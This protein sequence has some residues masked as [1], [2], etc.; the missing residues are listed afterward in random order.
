[1]SVSDLTKTN[2][3]ECVYLSIACWSRTVWQ[4]RVACH[5]AVWV[6][7]SPVWVVTGIITI[8]III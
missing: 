3:C 6:V 5:Q 4:W 2:T 8:I 7:Q 1:M